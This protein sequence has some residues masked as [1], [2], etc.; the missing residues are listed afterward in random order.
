MAQSFDDLV[1]ENH[2]PSDL[3]QES[4]RLELEIHDPNVVKY[5]NGFGCSE[6]E[7]KAVEALRV[8]VIAIQSASPTIDTKI[9]EERFLQIKTE[10]DRCLGDFQSDLKGQMEDHFKPGT[11]LM[12]RSIENLN[13]AMTQM[14]GQYFAPDDGKV[15]RLLQEQVGPQSQFAKSLDPN[16]RL[17]VIA[18]IEELVKGHLEKQSVEFVKQFS[19]DV[20]ESALSRLQSRITQEIESLKV[21]QN[22]AFAEMKEGLGVKAGKEAEAEKGT[23]KG[24]EFEDALYEHVASVAMQLDDTSENV[25]SVV[26]TLPRSK[27]GDYVITL[28][29]TSDAAG[30]CIV[31]EAKKKGNYSLKTALT[32]MNEA[33][34]NRQAAVGVLAFAKGYEPME[35]GDFRRIGND[36]YVTVDEEALENNSP[37][38]FFDA[39]YKIARALIVV[40]TRKEEKQELD[41]ESIRVEIESLSKLTERIADI[42]AKAKSIGTAAQSIEKVSNEMRSDLETRLKTVS[43]LLNRSQIVPQVTSGATA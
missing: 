42:S 1:A 29:D 26:G 7:T 38:L 12:P 24:I 2:L 31:V 21:S 16:N 17:S 33:K 34:E 36:F 30:Q 19:L 9:V 37:L 10:I 8:G 15:M 32:E 22:K 5:L 25:G 20:E 28:G 14:L 18:K 35:V 39:A 4:I 43:N 11:G 23:R 6:R 13:G 41:V 3:E 27:V 40:T